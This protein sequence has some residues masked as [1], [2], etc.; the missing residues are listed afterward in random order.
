M[1]HDCGK[2]PHVVGELLVECVNGYIQSSELVHGKGAVLGFVKSPRE[3]DC[4]DY[5]LFPSY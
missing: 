1:K 4:V 5:M 3:D 2:T